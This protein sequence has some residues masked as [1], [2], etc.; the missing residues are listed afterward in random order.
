MHYLDFAAL[1]VNLRPLYINVVR[2]PLE[3]YVLIVRQSKKLIF[4][5]NLQLQ[6]DLILLLPAIW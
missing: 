2:D 1:G 5:Q 3:R 4:N 6:T